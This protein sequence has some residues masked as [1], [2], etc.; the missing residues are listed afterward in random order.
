MS[1]KKK[2]VF[3]SSLDTDIL[4]Q[5][6]KI[7]EYERKPDWQVV[8]A[9]VE[10]GAQ[11]V[12]EEYGIPFKTTID[13]LTPE[14]HYRVFTESLRLAKEWYKGQGIEE[15]LS[16]K[17]VS[18]GE[19]MEYGFRQIFSG[20]LLDI[21]LCQGILE[22]EK[23]D[24][25]ALIERALPEIKTHYMTDEEVYD[26]FIISSLATAKGIPVEWVAPIQE[27]KVTLPKDAERR[28]LISQAFNRL[29]VII[30]YLKV[31]LFISRRLEVHRHFQQLWNFCFCSWTAHR[32]MRAFSQKK[33]KIAF[34]GLRCATNIADYLRK[35]SDNGVICL[36][37]PG[38]KRRAMSIVPS[39]YLESFSN[40]E[41]N[42]VVA[43]KG[44]DFIEILEQTEVASYL[45]KKL[46]YHDFNLWTMARGEIEYILGVYFPVMV[47]G[48]ELMQAMIDKIGLDIFIATSDVNPI[49]RAITKVLQN[50]GKKFLLI[51]H[52]VD[53]FG[54]EASEVYGKMLLPLVADKTATWGEASRNWYIS[55]GAPPDKLEATSCSD[56]DDHKRILNCSKDAIRRY[57]R[58]PPDK[59]AVLYNL[60]HG[61]RDSRVAYVGETRDELI[62]RVKDVTAEV[63]Q[64]PQLYL[65]VRPHPGDRHPEEIE[66]IVRDKKRDNVMFNPVL[67]LPYLLRVA[68]I[69]ITFVS[70]SALEAMI[71]DRDVIIYNQTGRPESVPYSRDGAAL[72]VTRKE[73]LVP[74][75]LEVLEN[76][77][78][79]AKL[80][81]SRKKFVGRGAGQIDGRATQNIANLILEMIDK[82]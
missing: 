9:A 23:P 45:E 47:R 34:Y 1:A 50:E 16:H 37:G 5:L 3:L 60:G 48:M 14:R 27:A 26:S 64:C 39:I 49:I 42:S 30:N 2:V 51:Q 31:A 77:S 72:K 19:M 36:M 67:P 53:Y 79:R 63:A 58:I 33:R 24:R 32:P 75:I 46:Y 44:K 10:R 56:F 82:G 25:I 57:L 8:V 40:P 22:S 6:G 55:Q 43:E 13:Y 65:I 62:Q 52:G 7:G 80:A 4:A 15:T 17:G 61:N 71:F 11:R 41:T 54:L 35:D 12:C 66:N 59:K 70:S 73:E 21:E 20:F 29:K 74:K 68:D 18:L 76:D 38:E 78:L 69:V 28:K 81:E